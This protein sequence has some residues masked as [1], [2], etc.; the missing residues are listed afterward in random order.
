MSRLVLHV[1]RSLLILMLVA[2]V[3]SWC[4]AYSVLTHEQVVDLL[5][6]D[7]IEPLLV[8]R[9]PQATPDELKK[10][11]AFA[12]GGSLVQDM[13]YYP[14]GNKYFSDLTHYVRSGDFIVNLIKEASDLNEYAFALGALAH[15]SADNMGHPTVNQSVAILFPDLRKKF[16]N[17]V[18]YE[19]NPKAHI[20]I[21]F[22]FDMTQVAKNRYT[23]DRYHDFIGFEVSKPVLERAFEDTYGIPLKEVIPKEDLAIGTFRRAISKIVPEMTR[24]ALLA[25]K[26]EMVSET[27]NFNAK[28]FRY[29]LSRTNYQREWG[30]GYRRPGFGTKVL[31][32]FLKFVPKIGPFKALAFTIPTRQTEDLYVASVNRTLDNYKSLLQEVKGKSLQLTN[33]DFDTGRLTRAG[34]Y[35]FTDRTYAHLLDQLAKD[36]FQQVTPDLRE[37]ILHFYKDP[38]GPVTTKSDRAAWERVQQELERLRTAEPQAKPAIQVIPEN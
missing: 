9:F 31:A 29:Y 26:K 14:F 7:Q 36:N 17:E 38:A 13:G 23:S 20:R 12:Y 30:K 18:T 1:R 3:G 33:T 28:K 37:N 10:A 27:P 21:E 2:G 35:K 25:R 22:G 32:F 6:K 16:G 34:E 24:V 5:W 19:D 11:H 8:K 4:A 15:Y